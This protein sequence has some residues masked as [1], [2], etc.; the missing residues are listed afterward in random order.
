MSGSSKAVP[1]AIRVLLVHQGDQWLAQAVDFDMSAQAPS[2]K[3]AVDA[4]LRI[5]RAHYRR[6][7]ELGRTPFESLPE[8]PRRFADAWDKIP[9]TKSRVIPAEDGDKMP[10]AYLIEA[11]AKNDSDINLGK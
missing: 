11:I 8:A 5:L 4:F 10:P 3:L 9:R 6:D 1:L 2:N 7:R